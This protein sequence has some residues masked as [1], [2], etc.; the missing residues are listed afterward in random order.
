M[1]ALVSIAVPH[2]ERRTATPAADGAAVV[3]HRRNGI[4]PRHVTKFT[5]TGAAGFADSLTERREWFQAH[6]VNVGR[7]ARR[8]GHPPGV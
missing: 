4:L 6:G 5:G 7:L 2:A 1:P 8:L 3:R